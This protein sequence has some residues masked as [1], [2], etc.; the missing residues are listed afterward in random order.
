[1]SLPD[2][3]TLSDTYGGP[4]T[5]ERPVED[6]TTEL[7][8]GAASEL[9]SDVAGCTRTVER[10]WV[11]F[12]GLTYTS[13]TQSIPVDDH[14]ANWGG[15]AGVEPVVVQTAAGIYLITWPA[16]VIDE[17]LVTRTLNIRYPH[18]P[19]TIDATLSRGKVSA[20]TA[21]TISLSTFNAAGSANS[22]NG[23]P[24]FVSWT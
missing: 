8:A 22:L 15:S 5:N 21:N 14:N 2:E 4:Y 18:E 16:T 7:D 10:A 17:I 6:P 24:I 23:I 1:M 11:K 9:M 19:V 20:F 13:G 3:A 12:N